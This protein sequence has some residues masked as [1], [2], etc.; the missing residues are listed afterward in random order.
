MGLCSRASNAGMAQHELEDLWF[1]ALIGYVMPPG[2]TSLSLPLGAF[3]H[4][5]FCMP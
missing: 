4:C 3:F 2:A 5:P 1:H